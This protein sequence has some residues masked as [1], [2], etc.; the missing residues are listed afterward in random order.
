M[1]FY[2][3]LPPEIWFIIYKFEHNI[4]LTYI[5]QEINLINNKVIG[6]NRMVELHP[7]FI[8]RW[9]KVTMVSY[10]RFNNSFNNMI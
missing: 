7:E 4:K 9:D 6:I 2:N 8:N 3:I 5:N 10:I 1:V